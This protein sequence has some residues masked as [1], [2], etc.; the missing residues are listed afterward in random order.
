MGNANPA[1]RFLMMLWRFGVRLRL[2]ADGRTVTPFGENV[3]PLLEVETQK[4]SAA[5]LPFVAGYVAAQE[6][7]CA[8]IEA[9]RGIDVRE[10]DRRKRGKREAVQ[11]ALFG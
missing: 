7:H 6:A 8:A 9:R 3:S 1:R 10:F 4:R 5:L 11:G 2:E